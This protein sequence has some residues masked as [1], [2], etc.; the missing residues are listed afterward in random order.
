MVTQPELF[1]TEAAAA[2]AG[3]ARAD[4]FANDQWKRMAYQAAVNVACRRD[5]L[6]SDDVWDELAVIA[7]GVVTRENRA[8][9]AVLRRAV[10]DRVVESTGTFVNSNRPGC[11]GTPT[12]WR[13]LVLVVDPS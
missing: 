12:V 11:H 6:I 10:K 7:P 8:M 9:G 13:S 1:G 2:A 3:M 5:T 4:A